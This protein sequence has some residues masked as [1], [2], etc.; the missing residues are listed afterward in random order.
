[1]DECD[2]FFSSFPRVKSHNRLTSR[3]KNVQ[4]GRFSVCSVNVILT[5]RYKRSYKVAAIFQRHN[6]S[7]SNVRVRRFDPEL[8]LPSV[9]SVA[10]SSHLPKTCR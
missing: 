3:H 10:A 5:C 6:V 7:S 8:G 1:M 4:T 2:F 9:W